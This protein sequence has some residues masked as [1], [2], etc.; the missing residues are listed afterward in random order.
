M[1]FVAC[2]PTRL[3]QPGA[4][5]FDHTPMS[6]SDLPSIIADAQTMAVLHKREL[7]DVGWREVYMLGILC[8]ALVKLSP[9]GCKYLPPRGRVISRLS[10]ICSFNLKRGAYKK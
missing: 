10:E 8:K 7:R 6:P 1:Q 3:L 5:H 9:M 4:L 2:S